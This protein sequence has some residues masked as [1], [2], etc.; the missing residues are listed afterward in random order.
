MVSC[1]LSNT[2]DIPAAS[3]KARLSE[4]FEDGNSVS[5]PAG[6]DGKLILK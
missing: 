1:A 6:I 2:N 5:F 4:R 3:K